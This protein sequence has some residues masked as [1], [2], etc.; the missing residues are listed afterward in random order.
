MRTLSLKL[1]L[2]VSFLIAGLLPVIAISLY[3]YH[4]TKEALEK[5]A[6]EQ[7]HAVRDIKGDAVVRYF[8]M[9]RDQVLTLSHDI[10]IQDAMKGFSKAFE[11]YSKELGYTNI[12]NIVHKAKM[13]DFY[14][15]QYGIKYQDENQ[16]TVDVESLIGRLDPNQLALQY[17]YI[18]MNPNPMGSKEIL[19]YANDNTTYSKLHAKYHEPIREFLQKFGYYDIFLIDNKSGNI[20]YSVYKEIDFATSLKTGSFNT[21]NFAEAFKKASELKDK[22]TFVLVDYQPYKPSFEAPASFIA[23]PIWDGDKKIGVL[24]FQMPIDRLNAIMNQRS[25]MGQTGETYLVGP[26]RLMRSDSYR[27]NESYSVISSFRNA[28]DRKIQSDSV[29]QAL[30]FK[31]GDLMT[32]NYQGD[33]V[34]SAFTPIN[35]LGLNWGLIAEVSVDEAFAAVNS[36]KNTLVVMIAIS[37]LAI[38]MFAFFLS[39]TLSKKIQA[40]ATKLI[41]SANEVAHSSDTISSSST[42][43]SEASTEA[44][45]SLQE[46]VS[47]IDEI[48][49]MIQ[50]NADA[51]NSSTQVS[52][53]SSD[54]ANRGKK[55]VESMITS[56]NDISK[57]NDDIAQEMTKNNEDIS[58]IVQVISEIGQKTKVI[59][60]IVFQT[61]LLSFNASVEAARA[62]EHGK[63]FCGC[64]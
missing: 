37:I 15:N 21:T 45:A 53:K 3:S 55:T 63:G 35:I 48:S 19:D 6:I 2:I 30:S 11:E 38:S 57:S 51:A 12:D 26:D 41:D 42:Q 64:C 54:A 31:S 1:R 58:K 44:A 18:G 50:R 32:Y 40:I 8:D 7:L 43:L 4:M 25:G 34:L 60:D 17:Q 16:E 49:S 59:N 28:E 22:E 62:G 47:S 39:S 9:I 23:S 14:S 52:S 56:I 13:K 24:V 27:N 29:Q 5:E 46:T 36:L 10:M 20:V 33:Y 61:K